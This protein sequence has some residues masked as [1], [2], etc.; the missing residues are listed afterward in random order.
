MY[1]P[2]V[3]TTYYKVLKTFKKISQQL[4]L[5]VVGICWK[6]L[7]KLRDVTNDVIYSTVLF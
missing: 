2:E 6:N 7:E 3:G 4:L 5:G 1:V